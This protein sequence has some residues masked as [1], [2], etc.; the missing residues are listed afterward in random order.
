MDTIT[1]AL[2]GVLLGRAS[3]ST[4]PQ[5][6]KNVL[7]LK[8]R[9]LAGFFAAAFPDID[10]VARFFG[11]INYLETH[12]GIT[13]SF[14]LLPL[15]ALLLSH[16]FSFISRKK[17]HWKD[18]YLVSALGLTIH[19]LGDVITA[20]GTMFLAPFSMAKFAVPTTFIIDP[21]FTGIILVSIILF[22]LFATKGRT[23]AVSGLVVLASY[24]SFQGVMHLEARSIAQEY[25]AKNNISYEKLYV[26][27]QPF[28]PFHWKMIIQE[29]NQYHISY[30]DFLKD[31]A[32]VASSEAGFFEKLDSLYQPVASLQW[33]QV[34]KF[35][36]QNEEY[37]EA[38][39]LRDE[40]APL[41]KFMMFPAVVDYQEQGCTWFIDH[42]FVLGNLRNAPFVFGACQEENNRF[43]IY[44]RNGETK[45]PV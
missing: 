19:I 21:Y 41:R 16:A 43:M 22:K 35:G 7:S 34:N 11:V 36:K 1:H 37:H 4:T 13:H 2:S 30:I 10:F 39:W 9:L 31:E 3:T 44:R 5:E 40:M 23:I 15:W 12:R 27:P 20:Y 38:K 18:F 25:A 26:M 8:A 6:N 29:K 14:I 28:S 33:S 32:L 42:R 45:E 17:Y 24:I